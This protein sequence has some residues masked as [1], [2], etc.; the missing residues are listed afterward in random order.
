[1]HFPVYLLG[2]VHPHPV[3]EGL[4]YL[5]AAQAFR[6]LR[7]RRGDVLDEDAR[8]WLIVAAVVG[9]AIG[10]KLL[11]WA[12]DPAATVL[13][14][15]LAAVMGGKSVVG[16][17]VGAL[18]AVELAKRRLGIARAT[19]DLFAMPC[20]LGIAVGRIGCFLTGLSDHTHGLPTT[21]PWG[22]DFG[23]GLPR[24]PT[25]LYEVAFL[26]GLS[27]VLYRWRPAREG[28]TFKLF[29][30]CYAAFRIWLELLKPGIFF[31]PLNAV[32]W[33]CLAVLVYYAPRLRPA[34][35]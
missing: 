18:G 11:Y 32:Q 15:S 14:G 25:Q 6:W 7:A 1:M 22:V 20:A 10:S 30:A 9:G 34:V 3:F 16:G 27:A 21:L 31:G 13:D 23:D 35:A 29:L 2:V 26:L 28:D 33:V 8:G 17:L 19:G 4:G 5:A 24:H 12:S